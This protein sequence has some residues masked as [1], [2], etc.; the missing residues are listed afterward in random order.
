M[1]YMNHIDQID[2]IGM[3]RFCAYV[4]CLLCDLW[5]L[6]NGKPILDQYKFTI[7]GAKGLLILTNP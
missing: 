3:D 4:L 5:Y 1:K 2:H 7:R 6:K